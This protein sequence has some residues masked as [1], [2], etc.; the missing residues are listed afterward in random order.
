MI[1]IAALGPPL[2]TYTEQY[3][4]ALFILS[5]VLWPSLAGRRLSFIKDK[6]HKSDPLGSFRNFRLTLSLNIESRYRL[7]NINLSRFA[8]RVICCLFV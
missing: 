8:D 7:G 3:T 1:L 4:E 6:C 5:L 2:P